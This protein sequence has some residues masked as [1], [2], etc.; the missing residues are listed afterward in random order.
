MKKKLVSII[1]PFFNEE[2][3]LYE[4]LNTVFNQTY[5]KWELILVN[6]N[7]TDN[8]V[9]KIKN[10]IKDKRI[11]LIHNKHNFGPAK[12]RN[13]GLKHVKGE[14]ICFLDS[15]DLW[16]PQKI[17]K[18]LNFMIKHKLNFSCSNYQPFRNLKKKLKIIKLKKKI[19]FEDFIYDTSIAT[20]AMMIKR[21]IQKN[22]FFNE[23]FYFD[24]YVFK[25]DLLKK[26]FCY[27]INLNLMYYRIKNK[28]ISSNKIKNFLEVWK[29]NRKYN[30][31]SIYK[32]LYSISCISINS[33][34]KYGFK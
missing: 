15:D 23:N 19:S 28:S 25:L 12:S 11:K 3:Y 18:Q 13:I 1:I 34:R 26:T 31:F 22:I 30:K 20:S 21:S 27:N 2:Y 24:D 6:D 33:L 29:T 17:E 9:N 8:S 7:S 14:Y 4:T 10:F 5:K 32:S 16:H